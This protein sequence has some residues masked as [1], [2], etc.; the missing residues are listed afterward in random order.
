MKEKIKSNSITLDII[1]LAVSLY[2]SYK[3]FM[4][5]IPFNP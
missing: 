5:I 2:C 3:I 4:E 1:F